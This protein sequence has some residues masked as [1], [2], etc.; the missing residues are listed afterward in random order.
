MDEISHALDTIVEVT[1]REAAR[2]ADLS[3]LAVGQL[4]L[5]EEVVQAAGEVRRVADHNAES[6]RSVE[7]SFGEQRRRGQALESSSRQLAVLAG[8]LAQV[9]RRFRL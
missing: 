6:T 9:T 8:E 2:V 7:S 4:K 1:R 3:T 5:A